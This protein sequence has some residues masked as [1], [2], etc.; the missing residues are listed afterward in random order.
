MGKKSKRLQKRSHDHRIYNSTIDAEQEIWNRGAPIRAKDYCHRGGHR[1]TKWIWRKL[2]P[3]TVWLELYPG[4]ASDKCVGSYADIED[5]YD[6]KE[7]E[8]KTRERFKI[9]TEP[10][11]QCGGIYC[12]AQRIQAQDYT[13]TQNIRLGRILIVIG[14]LQV[15]G[16]ALSQGSCISR[17]LPQDSREN[18]TNE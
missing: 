12:K 3:D 17:L 15:L 18:E 8:V 16:L 4:Q 2:S 6:K 14:L 10:K 11:T 9:L 5:F 13:A 7:R 1:L